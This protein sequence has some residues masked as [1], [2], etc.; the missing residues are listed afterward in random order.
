MGKPAVYGDLS[1]IHC[2]SATNASGLKAD[3]HGIRVPAGVM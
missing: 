2:D 1:D 3:H